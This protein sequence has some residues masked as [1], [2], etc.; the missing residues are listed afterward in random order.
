MGLLFFSKSSYIDN[1]LVFNFGGSNLYT[2]HAGILEPE[3]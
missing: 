1:Y 3:I 2:V